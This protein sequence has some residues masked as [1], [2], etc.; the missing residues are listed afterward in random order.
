MVRPKKKRLVSELPSVCFFK[1][2][3]VPLSQLKTIILTVEDFEALKLI[4]LNELEQK[5]A[6]EI[7]GVS[8]PTLFRVLNNARKKVADAIVNGKAIRID[9]GDYVVGKMGGS[10]LGLG[11]NCLCPKCGKVVLHQRGVPCYKLIC[12]KCGSKMVRK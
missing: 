9:G 6:A 1:P 10:V 11:G 5:E 7:M 12:E 8:Q 2:Q 3:A 4:D